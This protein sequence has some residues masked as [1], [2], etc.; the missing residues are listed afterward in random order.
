[1]KV[2]RNLVEVIDAEAHFVASTP[3]FVRLSHVGFDGLEFLFEFKAT[4][5]IARFEIRAEGRALTRR[6]LREVPFGKL[7]REARA[8]LREAGGGVREVDAA[9]L[10]PELRENLAT[11]LSQLRAW[12]AS[13]SRPGRAG[14]SDQYYAGLASA[15]VNLVEAGSDRPNACLASEYSLNVQTVTSQLAEAR[16]RGLLSKPPTPG[17]AGGDLTDKGKAALRD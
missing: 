2:H 4:G 15:Y 9:T 10:D 12:S 16:R 6:L 1:M 14:R 8:W 5:E 3:S 7:E 13:A 11:G 17:C